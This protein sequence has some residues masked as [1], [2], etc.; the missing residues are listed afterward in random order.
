MTMPKLAMTQEMGTILQWYKREGD[1]VEAGEPLLEVMT[2]KINMD[3]ESYVDGV[4]RKRLYEEGA[5]VPVLNVIAY[6]G[7]ADEPLPDNNSGE[8]SVSSDLSH[9]ETSAAHHPQKSV[10]TRVRATPA[11][12]AVA[13]KLGVLLTDVRGTGPNNRIQ[14]EDVEA[15]AISRPSC[16]T[17]TPAERRLASRTASQT[18]SSIH[19]TPEDNLTAAPVDSCSRVPYHGLRKMVG[20]RMATSAS[21]APHVTLVREID[22]TQTLELRRRLMPIV[23]EQTGAHLSLNTMV[24]FATAHALAKHPNVNATWASKD[25]IIQHHSVHLGMAVAAPRGLMVPVIHFANTLSILALSEQA[26]QLVKRARN[27]ALTPDDLEGG[28]FTMSNLGMFGIESFNPIIN[29]PQVAILG[30]GALIEKPI[31]ENGAIV[32]RPMLTLNLSFDHRVLDGADAAKFLQTVADYLTCPDELFV[33][34][35]A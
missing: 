30:V 28:T 4:L 27:G 22:V 31:V 20:D 6:I 10:S 34:L 19:V 3:V 12:R 26:S 23:E 5:E 14:R 9:S 16:S 11:A 33:A 7:D 17:T 15:F 25:E 29:F 21:Q 1:W 8:L 32:V 18:E 13:R 2:N 24:L 35:H